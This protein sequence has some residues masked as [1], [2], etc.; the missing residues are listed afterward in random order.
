MNSRCK[1][2]KMNSVNKHCESQVCFL[3]RNQII[4]RNVLLDYYLKT[5]NTSVKKELN[6]FV[7]QKTY[8]RKV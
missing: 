1:S 4:N 3:V 5:F 6:E 2:I 8:L 7:K